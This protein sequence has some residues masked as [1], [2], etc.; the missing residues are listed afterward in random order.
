MSE[1]EEQRQ[2]RIAENKAK[3]ESLGLPQMAA[4]CF[5]MATQNTGK[6]KKTYVKNASQSTRNNKKAKK[7]VEED[8][9]EYRPEDEELDQLDSS[10]D[11][12]NDEVDEFT[13][14]SS[15]SLKRKVCSIIIFL[16]LISCF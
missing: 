13:K 3:L 7:K 12:E 15:E 4:N 1:Y 9:E 11:D 10:T 6:N 8:E 5:K 16:Q 14:D 2:Q